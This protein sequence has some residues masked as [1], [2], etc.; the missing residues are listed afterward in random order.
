VTAEAPSRRCRWATR[1]PS[2]SSTTSG[3][4]RS[5]AGGRTS[6]HTR[7]SRR[8]R[9]SS[10][11]P[12]PSAPGSSGGSGSAGSVRPGLGDGIV[13]DGGGG[14]PARPGRPRGAV[15]LP[16]GVLSV[17]WGEATLY[18]TGPAVEVASGTL[19]GRWL[20]AAAPDRHRGGAHVTDPRTDVDVEVDEPVLELSRAQRRRAEADA[21]AT[22]RP[23]R[24]WRSS[25]RSRRPSSSGCTRPG[26][27]PTTSTPPSTSSRSC[28]TPPAVNR[29]SG[30]PEAGSA[31]RRHV[32]RPR[33]GRRAAAARLRARRGRRRLRRRPHA[34]AAAQ[35]RGAAEGQGP[36]PHHRHPRHLRQHHAS[37]R[38]G[39]A[40]V[41]LAQL[42]YLLPRLRGWGQALSRQAGGGRPAGR[43]LRG[44]GETQ[45]EVDRRKLNRRINKLRATC[46]TS[47]RP[48]ASRPRTASARACHRRPRRLHQRRQVDAAEPADRRRRARRRPAVRH[49]RHDRSTLELPDAARSSSPTPSG[50]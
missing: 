6:P 4:P 18:V 1:T 27:R 40:Q 41:E 33:Q 13:G 46:A 36:R 5:T 14:A 38:E 34:G 29:R 8:G 3:A 10:S 37:S 25:A 15:E 35:P 7:R 49:P 26:S 17:D 23:A 47:R 42:T 31:R 43:A 32:H 19:D 20:A 39:K 50:S 16:G 2:S 48:A 30:R 24:A 45:L 28:S 11:S 21:S 12:S 22:P 9:T 44:P